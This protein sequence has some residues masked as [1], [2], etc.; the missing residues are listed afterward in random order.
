MKEREKVLSGKG[1]QA[2]GIEHLGQ[3]ALWLLSLSKKREPE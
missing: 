1:L 3:K 2:F